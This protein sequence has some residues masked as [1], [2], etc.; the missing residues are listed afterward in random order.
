MRLHVYLQIALDRE[1]L[2]APIAL[3]G[4]LLGV[5]PLVLGQVGGIAEGLGAEAAGE[6]FESRLCR[7]VAVDE[8]HPQVSARLEGFRAKVAHKFFTLQI[9]KNISRVWFGKFRFFSIR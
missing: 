9:G 3:E 7:V 2:V 8:M 1:L 6:G 4:F 5:N